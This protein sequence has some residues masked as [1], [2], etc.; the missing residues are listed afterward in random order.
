VA[1]CVVDW[2]SAGARVLWLAGWVGGLHGPARWLAGVCVCD[3]GGCGASTVSSHYT[4]STCTHTARTHSLLTRPHRQ[5]THPPACHYCTP[6]RPPTALT[7]LLTTCTVNYREPVSRLP[8]GGTVTQPCTH[9][10]V[11]AVGPASVSCRS[12]QCHIAR[13]S[14]QLQA[15]TQVT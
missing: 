13:S 7:R 11:H 15:A 10:S 2:H 9:C 1:V 6:D 3:A 14:T 8:A 12:V 4:H 5:P